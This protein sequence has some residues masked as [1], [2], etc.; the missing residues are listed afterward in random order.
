MNTFSVKFTLLY[1][2]LITGT[3][4]GLKFLIIR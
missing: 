3:K 1:E 4:I 2:L